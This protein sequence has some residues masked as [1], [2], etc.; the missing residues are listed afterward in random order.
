MRLVGLKTITGA[1]FS[2]IERGFYL[3][4]EGAKKFIDRFEGEME[5]RSQRNA[6]SLKEA[7]YAQAL[8][9]RNWALD[10]GVLSFHEWKP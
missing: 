4:R 1:D 2:A 6:L 10:E 9:I 8:S 7:I 3:T 5:M